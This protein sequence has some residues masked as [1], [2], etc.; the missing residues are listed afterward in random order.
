MARAEATVSPI[1]SEP[2]GIYHSKARQNLSS[3]Q[4]ADFRKCPELYHRKQLGLIPDQDRP[5]YVIGRAA[6]CLILEGEEKFEATYAVGGPTNPKTGKPFGAQTKKYAE[7]AAE[8]GKDVLTNVQHLLFRHV[9]MRVQGRV[10]TATRRQVLAWCGP[11]HRTARGGSVWR[12]ED[13]A[14]RYTVEF[15]G[16]DVV[17]KIGVLVMPK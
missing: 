8:Q 16:N 5:S 11:P 12:Y 4:L 2:E 14:V 9:F 13:G 10:G 6:H 7:W 3:H 1:I 15:D 17:K